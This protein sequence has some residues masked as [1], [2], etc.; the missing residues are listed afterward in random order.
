M[1]LNLDYAEELSKKLDEYDD[2]KDKVYDLSRKIIKNSKLCI[3]AIRRKEYDKAKSYLDDIEKMR[4][5]IYDLIKDNLKLASVNIVST[6]DQEYVEA[7]AL[8]YFVTKG[9]IPRA[10]EIGVSVQEY[11]AGVMDSAGEMLRL[12]TDYLIEGKIEEAEKIRDAIEK[13]YVFMLH[14]N[15]R[16]YELR[17]KIDYVSNVLNKLQEFIFY[18]KVLG[19]VKRITGTEE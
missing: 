8:Y 10:E 5:E 2:L 11:V 16:D 4:A 9:E 14:V 18:K 6:A 3:Y 19:P 1:V 12:A 13:I 7:L 17:R 15:P